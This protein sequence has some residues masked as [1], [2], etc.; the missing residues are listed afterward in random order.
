MISHVSMSSVLKQLNSG[1]I[2]LAKPIIGHP[3]ENIQLK[4]MCLT[5]SK[6]AH[7]H[8]NKVCGDDMAAK[9]RYPTHLLAYLNAVAALY[10]YSD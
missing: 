1:F 10:R 6:H 3:A 9:R 2:L 5:N 7:I 4:H 8:I